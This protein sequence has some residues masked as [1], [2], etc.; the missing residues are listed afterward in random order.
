MRYILDLAASLKTEYDSADPFSLA[1]DLD[2]LI[3]YHDL[4]A[5]KGYYLAEHGIR[6]IVINCSLEKRMQ[7]LVCAHELGHDCLHQKIAGFSI[8]REKNI[9]A[10]GHRAEKEANLF[11]AELLIPDSSI[12]ELL[13]QECTLDQICKQLG[14]PQDL[15]LLKLYALNLNGWQFNP[16]WPI[17]ASFL[18]NNL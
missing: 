3:R 11:A 2:I 5:L 1:R 10:A 13:Y 18:K 7:E 4:G 14:R 12:L 16:A 17:N 8:W 9:F 6:F 15:I